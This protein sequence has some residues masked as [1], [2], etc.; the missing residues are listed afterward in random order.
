MCKY[1]CHECGEEFDEPYEYEERHGLEYGPFEK[2][3]VCPC[4]GN[5]GYEEAKIDGRED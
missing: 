2:W 3:S 5:P 4:C 1:V